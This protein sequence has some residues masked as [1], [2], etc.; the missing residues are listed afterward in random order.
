MFITKRNRTH[1]GLI[2]NTR[3]EKS[4]IIIFVVY[5]G[6]NKFD[7]SAGIIMFTWKKFHKYNSWFMNIAGT[8]HDFQKLLSKH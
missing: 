6:R 4:Q 3:N 7:D 5:S 8:V 1:K 2:R